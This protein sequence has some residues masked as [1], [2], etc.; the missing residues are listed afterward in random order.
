M[1]QNQ[2]LA[3]T[4][5]ANLKAAFS[6][7]AENKQQFPLYYESKLHFTEKTSPT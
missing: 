7:F 1:L 5:L 3:Q 4:G 6:R 2:K